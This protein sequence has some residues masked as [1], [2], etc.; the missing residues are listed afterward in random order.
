MAEPWGMAQANSPIT[1][2]FWGGRSLLLSSAIGG[3]RATSELGTWSNWLDGL[4]SK[5][6]C[7]SKKGQSSKF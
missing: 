7:W 3:D 6:H 2:R 5:L 1:L 4:G